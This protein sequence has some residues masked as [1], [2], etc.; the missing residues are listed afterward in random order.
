MF[1]VG[2]LILAILMAGAVLTTATSTTN[3]NAPAANVG[4]GAEVEIMN[5]NLTN[6]DYIVYCNDSSNT[7]NVSENLS[8]NYN[9]TN[10]QVPVEWENVSSYDA[11]DGDAWNSSAD[12][13]FYNASGTDAYNT[14]NDWIIAGKTPGSNKTEN[15]SKTFPTEWHFTALDNNTKANSGF[16]NSTDAIVYDYCDGEYDG[17]FG[18]NFTGINITNIAAGDNMPINGS[19]ANITL[20]NESGT[21]IAT[22][23]TSSGTNWINTTFAEAVAFNGTSLKF[24]VTMTVNDTTSAWYDNFDNV[25][26]FD[27]KASAELSLNASDKTIINANT[28]MASH[29]MMN[30]EYYS[31]GDTIEVTWYNDSHYDTFLQGETK[32]ATAKLE[33][34]NGEP[35]PDNKWDEQEITL[36]YDDSIGAFVTSIPTTTEDGTDVFTIKDGFTV[37]ANMTTPDTG[38][39]DKSVVDISAPSAVSIDSPTELQYN[40][41]SDKIKVSYSYNESNPSETTIIF[42]GP[43]TVE[44]VND[45]SDT[46]GDSIDVNKLELNLSEPDTGEFAEGLYS[47]KLS[48]EDAAGNVNNTEILQE[49]VLMID[50]TGPSV[51]GDIANNITETDNFYDGYYNNSFAFNLTFDLEDIYGEIDENTVKLHYNYSDSNGTINPVNVTVVGKTATFNATIDTEDAGMTDN[52]NIVFWLEA[53]DTVGNVIENGGSASAPL[54]SY[55]VDTAAPTPPANFDAEAETGVIN[56]NWDAATDNASGVALYNIYRNE[57]GTDFNFSDD[58]DYI[59]NTTET[60]YSDVASALKADVNYNYTVVAVDNLGHESDEAD[61]ANATFVPGVPADITFDTTDSIIVAD[62]R[63]TTQI[64]ATI[65]DEHGRII[66]SGN[67]SFITDAGTLNVTDGNYY[68]VTEGKYTVNLTSAMETGVANVTA[69]LEG[70]DITNT[71]QVEFADDT[72]KPLDLRAGWNMM[73]L[74]LIPADSSI[75]EVLAGIDED[76]DVEY[77]WAYDAQSNNWTSYSA[78]SGGELEEMVD[79]KGYLLKTDSTGTMT[80]SGYEDV[81][82]IETPRAYDVYEGWN[83]IGFKYTDNMN[84]SEYLGNVATST[85]RLYGLGGELEMDEVMQPGQGYWL[86]VSQDGTIYPPGYAQVK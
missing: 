84:S 13:I 10:G 48:V 23:K 9:I 75:E 50:D 39:Y 73:S 41:S 65:V 25:D 7:I 3:N 18:D 15:I 62:G 17:Y 43:T 8:E 30:K 14:S 29:I 60:S 66:Q 83:L 68:E 32:T 71:T 26:A 78:V 34:Y 42:E 70:T 35:K 77:V 27:M 52:T 55:T 63:N 82:L 49:D 72:T 86:A 59:A 1:G 61:P 79:G 20:Y 81:D 44:F 16:N 40:T 64:T 19:L 31:E 28:V 56:L 36:T 80:V 53:N 54:V 67:L 74:P 46:S 21:V 24:N 51:V 57:T 2:L 58:G 12:F 76:T 6:N 5:F 4:P 22:N 69:S 45:D 33:S 11:V 38:F 37:Y 85:D 47:I